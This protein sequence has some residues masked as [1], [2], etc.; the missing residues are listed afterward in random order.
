MQMSAL[1]VSKKQIRNPQLVLEISQAKVLVMTGKLES[2]ISPPLAQQEV[3]RVVHF[4]DGEAGEGGHIHA[5]LHDGG[6]RMVLA[7][8]SVMELVT[9]EDANDEV[10]Q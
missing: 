7:F 6:V 4:D 5:N 2:L 1:G 8:R 9:A 3:H 10:L